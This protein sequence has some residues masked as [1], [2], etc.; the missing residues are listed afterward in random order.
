M[1]FWK[2]PQN[3]FRGSGS[4]H[5]AALVHSGRSRSRRARSQ[6]WVSLFYGLVLLG[7]FLNN[8]SS[9]VVRCGSWKTSNNGSRDVRG[10]TVVVGEGVVT[11]QWIIPSLFDAPLTPPNKHPNTSHFRYF[12]QNHFLL[13]SIR[14]FISF[15]SA[16]F[17]FILL[18]LQIIQLWISASSQLKIYVK[19]V[20]SNQPMMIFK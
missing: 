19:K 20:W 16:G 13:I 11:V 14:N 18:M 10:K 6:A 15:P 17:Q 4:V 3:V 12:H 8:K 7:E 2:N 1:K 5:G 9:L